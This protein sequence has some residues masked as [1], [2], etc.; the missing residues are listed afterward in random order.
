M[1]EAVNKGVRLAT[2]D[3]IGLLHSDDVFCDKDVVR[4]I[5]DGFRQKDPV[6]FVYG[7]GVF[8][9][10]DNPERTVRVWKSGEYSLS[11]VRHGW[12]PLHPTCY[13]RR[14]FMGPPAPYD[15]KYKI[16]ADTDFLLRLLLRKNIRVGYL[17]RGVVRMRMGGLSTDRK[18]R[19]RMWNE[20]I[21]IFRSCGFRYPHLTK[22]E[23][24]LWKVPQFVKAIFT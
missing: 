15:E 9:D 3:V 6:D 4:D 5:V 11:K 22:I 24:M 18:L 8:V 20:D 13:V 19:R 16:A 10:S 12:L 2:G 7:D 23:K 14:E 1:Y 17:R 21:D